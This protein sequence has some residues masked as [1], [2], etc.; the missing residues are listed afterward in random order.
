[1]AAA[2]D[3]AEGDSLAGARLGPAGGRP[4]EQGSIGRRAG[5]SK[6]LPMAVHPRGQAAFVF[7][8]RGVGRHGE[9][10]QL[11]EGGLGGAGGGPF[12]SRRGRASGGR[13]MRSP[14]VRGWAARRSS[15]FLAVFSDV[16]PR[17]P[18][19]EDFGRQL[20]IHRVVSTRRTRRP[21]RVCARVRERPPPGDFRRR[22]KPPQIRRQHGFVQDVAARGRLAEW[23]RR[24]ESMAET[25]AVVA[26]SGISSAARRCSTA[27]PGRSG[28]TQSRAAGRRAPVGSCQH[29]HRFA[30]GG[31]GVQPGAPFLPIPTPMAA[32]RR[33]RTS[34]NRAVVGDQHPQAGPPTG[35]LPARPGGAWKTQSDGEGR[36]RAEYAGAPRS[37]PIIAEPF[38]DQAEAGPAEAAV[39][40]PSAW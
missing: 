8:A 7:A 35:W 29:S 11:G 36:C 5:V 14:V 27:S 32:K 9:N 12:R 17:P 24:S 40:E 3:E 13:R 23:R 25:M 2:F 1:M 34:G 38:D 33:L 19:G 31:R 30:A 10:R 21:S 18:A 16:P 20:L 37:P 22:K 28:R 26:G 15:A 6:G 39:M 4:G